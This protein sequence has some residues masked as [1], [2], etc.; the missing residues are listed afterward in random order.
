M[1]RV[2]L[3]AFLAGLVLVV[4]STPEP[5]RRPASAPPDVGAGFNHQL[6]HLGR[7]RA[8][9]PLE[10]TCPVPPPPATKRE[11]GAT[12]GQEPRRPQRPARRAAVDSM[13]K[14]RLQRLARDGARALPSS[15]AHT[16]SPPASSLP[17]PHIDHQADDH[18]VDEDKLLHKESQSAFG[19]S[20]RVAWR[21]G[22]MFLW[23]MGSIILGVLAHLLSRTVQRVCLMMIGKGPYGEAAA[24]RGMM[25]VDGCGGGSGNGEQGLRK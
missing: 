6:Q 25:G 5:C 1:I 23:V 18:S 9:A 4:A 13:S 24:A 19:R 16:S 8:P 15:W 12:D 17:Q 2:L 7:P 11:R 3:L 21:V 22:E 20:L 10:F 14:A